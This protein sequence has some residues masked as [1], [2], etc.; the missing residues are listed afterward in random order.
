M[1]RAGKVYR[2]THMFI[3]G[4]VLQKFIGY[5]LETIS[6]MAILGASGACVSQ[7]QFAKACGAGH[8]RSVLVQSLSQLNTA[9]HRR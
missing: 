3:F 8:Q 1:D 7:P 4:L 9:R 6:C 5:Q 2:K